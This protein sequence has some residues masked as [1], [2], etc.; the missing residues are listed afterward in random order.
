MHEDVLLAEEVAE[1]RHEAVVEE[2]A[3][4]ELVRPA[5]VDHL[6]ALFLRQPHALW[7]ETRA[8]RLHCSGARHLRV[9]GARHVQALEE[10]VAG[11]EEAAG[12]HLLRA[13]LHHQEAVL[14]HAH[15]AEG[16]EH[17]GARRGP[18][19]GHDNEQLASGIF[20]ECAGVEEESNAAERLRHPMVVVGRPRADE[21]EDVCLNALEIDLS[22]FGKAV[23]P[24]LEELED[25]QIVEED[26]VPLVEDARLLEE[27][28]FHLDHRHRPLAQCQR[29]GGEA[30]GARAAFRQRAVVTIVFAHLYAVGA[31]RGVQHPRAQ[32]LVLRM[33]V[34]H[35]NVVR[36]LRQWRLVLEERPL[37]RVRKL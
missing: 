5:D 7:H 19:L 8:E 9:D 15:E 1:R 10:S 36:V 37:A 32:R 26:L 23:A 25:T 14:V 17:E 12:V 20:L 27:D 30:E 28:V 29:E 6:R 33:R 21:E 18:V 31:V 35:H 34:Q 4:V 2:C 16:L 13:H 22:L 24:V 11:V 3:P